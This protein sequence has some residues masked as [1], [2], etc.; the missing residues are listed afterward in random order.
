M[1]ATILYPVVRYV[2]P[3][4]LPEA[5]TSRTVAAREGEQLLRQ[6]GGTVAGLR[7]RMNAFFG[8]RDDGRDA[9]DP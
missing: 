9:G 4:D 1:C 5:Q 6:L 8:G 7:D 2:V 3:P